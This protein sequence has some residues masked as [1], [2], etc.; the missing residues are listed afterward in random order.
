MTYAVSARPSGYCGASSSMCQ[1]GRKIETRSST[2][3]A[4]RMMEGAD[5]GY[6]LTL[7]AAAAAI[8]R[9]SKLRMITRREGL[10]DRLAKKA[11]A[12][13]GKAAAAAA[14]ERGRVMGT[15]EAIEMALGGGEGC[16]KVGVS[17]GGEV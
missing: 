6:F 3:A 5:H 7:T 11:R 1:Y 13:L 15:D 8:R 10:Q 4:P 17:A 16:G 12:S 9:Q 14:V 2:R